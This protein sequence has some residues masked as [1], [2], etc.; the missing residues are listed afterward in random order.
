M[1]RLYFDPA[2]QPSR[3]AQ[4]EVK[5]ASSDQEESAPDWLISDLTGSD[6]LA[7]QGFT[8]ILDSS[9]VSSESEEVEASATQPVVTEPLE[10]EPL[11]A[12]LQDAEKQ[13][14]KTTPEAA[15]PDF[16]KATGWAEAG[17]IDEAT[18]P[19]E[20][21]AMEETPAEGE[22]VPGNIPDWLQT[23]APQEEAAEA[24]AKKDDF[25][26]WLSK[27]DQSPDT[28][29]QTGILSDEKIEAPDAVPAIPD[30]LDQSKGIEPSPEPAPSAEPVSEM[31]NWLSDIGKNLSTTAPLQPSAFEEKP[32]EVKPVEKPVIPQPKATGSLKFAVDDN[33][34]IIGGTS[35]LSP[36]DV[37]DWLQDLEPSSQP[38]TTS[39]SDVFSST[40]SLTPGRACSCRSSTRVRSRPNS[41][42]M[43][44]KKFLNG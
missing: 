13:A 16:L 21:Y 6:S 3:S 44:K 41:P 19:S 32:A 17:S 22:I 31:P 7:A 30:W 29:Q 12:W 26:D 10:E 43:I 8:R 38:S 36:D 20:S 18:P 28:L 42:L 25:T 14:P 4:P 15:I 2:T 9:V 39:T 27:L 23:L 33:F 34:P 1:D 5:P 37:P 24:E 40:S 35:I 11:P